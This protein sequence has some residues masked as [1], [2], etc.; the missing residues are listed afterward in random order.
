MEEKH[1]H[2]VGLA[3]VKLFLA[4]GAV[5]SVFLFISLAADGRSGANTLDPNKVVIPNPFTQV[6]ISARAAYVYDVRTKEVLYAKNE[7]A[8]L[9]LASLTKVMTALVASDIAGDNAIVTIT[10]EAIMED[11][12]SGLLVGERFT[13]KN[14]LDFS[15]TTS[16]N[17][18]IHAAALAAGAINAKSNDPTLAESAFLHAMN[19]RADELQMKN[20]YY[21]NDTGLDMPS[22]QDG[23]PA[24]SSAKAGAYGSAEDMAKLFEYVISAHPELLE[25][26]QESSSDIASLNIVHHAR[27]T[28][29]LANL[30][31]GLIASKTG[32]TDIA[33]G[34]LII[35]FD[36]ELDHPVIISVL[37]STESGRFED[38]TAL[39]NATMES[40]STHDGASGK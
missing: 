13:M 37:G 25:A 2:I 11:G 20:T 39:V 22:G 40:L 19:T 15:L 32:F 23:L 38:M 33:G 18:G 8:R 1:K 36:P 29:I 14:L 12:D 26:T 7:K 16:S 21:Y 24:S 9:P 27:N 3:E 17:D 34:N 4:L 28:D 31:P 5:L 30:I 6:R 10:P 35:A